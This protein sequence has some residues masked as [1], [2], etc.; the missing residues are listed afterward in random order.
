MRVFFKAQLLHNWYVSLNRH[1]ID[2]HCLNPLIN[3]KLQNLLFFFLKNIYVFET[4]SYR[5]TQ[6]GRE[7]EIVH[8]QVLDVYFLAVRR[9]RELQPSLPCGHSCSQTVGAASAFPRLSS[10]SWIRS[11]MAASQMMAFHTMPQLP[12]NSVF[13]FWLFSL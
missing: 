5:D 8:L 3:Q 6:T 13:F 12:L 10:G 4:Q 11:G 1:V 2:D 7:R 9:T